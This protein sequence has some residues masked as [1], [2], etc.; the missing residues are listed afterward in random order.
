MKDDLN[1]SEKRLIAALDRL[2]QYIDRTASRAAVPADGLQDE[3]RRLSD[4]LAALHDKQAALI[5]TFETRLAEANDR[6]SAASDEAARLAAANEDLARANRALLEGVDDAPH[7]ALQAEIAA[8]RAARD[9]EVAQMGD[10]V[11]TL[12]RMLGAPAASV[13]PADTPAIVESPVATDAALEDTLA[14]SEQE[15]G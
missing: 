4:E 1:A 5:A 12:D 7:Q 10:I 14:A 6:L 11:D 15:R 8:L 2:D 9:A 13:R 3:N